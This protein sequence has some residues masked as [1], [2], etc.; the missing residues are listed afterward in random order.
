MG[1]A[2]RV[3]EPALSAALRQRTAFVVGAVALVA[4]AGFA[5]TRMGSEFVPNLDEGDIAMHAL[6]I[7]GTSLSQAIQMQRSLEARLKRF[8]EGERIVAKIGTAEIATDPMPPSVADTFIM[9]KDRKDWPD[10]RKPRTDLVRQMHAAAQTIPGNNYEFTQPIQ[11]RFNELLSGVRADVAIKVFGDDLDELLGVGEAIEKVVNG[12]EGAADVGVEQ[13]TGL[14]VLQI[15]PDRAALARLGL[16]VGDI[17]DVVAV[18]IGGRE[19]GQLFE[20]DRRFPVVVRL[21]EDIRAKVDQIGRL[22]VPLPA[23]SDGPRGFVPVEDVAKVEVVIG[24][25]QISREDGK[26]RVV[27]TANVRGRDLGS[28]IEELRKK[29]DADVEI[30]PGYWIS[31]GGTFEQLISAA[32]RLQLVVPAAML[33]IFRSEERRVGKECVSTCRSRWSP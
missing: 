6:R 22:R 21:P 1:W 27:V 5:A 8:P 13:V 28:F 24:P 7:P 15:T 12:I 9:L 31:Y 33:M 3:Y 18:S 2:R 11:M 4:L 29:V 26:R 30:P 19:A 17:Q 10:P 20:G 16:N 23:T 32:K 25:N 14:P